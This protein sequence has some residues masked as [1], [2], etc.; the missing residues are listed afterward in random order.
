M[1]ANGLGII[2]F[3]Y[4][5]WLYKRGYGRDT[6]HQYT[7][8]V[9]HFGFWRGKEKGALSGSA[10]HV[11]IKEFLSAQLDRCHCPKPAVTTLKTCRPALHRLLEMLGCTRAQPK[12]ANGLAA[13]QIANFD[14][15]LKEVS[16]LSEATRLYRRRY[17]LEFLEW[18]FKGRG[19]DTTKLRGGDF[20]EYIRLRSSGLKP[21]SVRVMITSLRSWI[22]FV[23]FEG[24]CLSGLSRFLPTVANWKHSLPSPV[25]TPVECRRLL[26]AINPETPVGSRDMAIVRLMLDL[27]LRCSEV[28][29]LSLEDIDWR[30]GTLIIRRNKQRRERLLP[31]PPSVG[32]AIS[33]Y[34]RQGR[35]VSLSRRLFLCHRIPLGDPI[36]VGRVRGAVRRA[37]GR[38]GMTEDGTHRL[39]HAFAT[40]LHERGASLKEVADI[41][42]HQNLDTT[43]IY[44][45]V[46]EVQL[47][48][49]A[50]PWPGGE[51]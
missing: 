22:R 35:P 9:E 21:A 37:M 48:E 10:A 26:G 44:A 29:G 17:V 16:G 40:R 25:L 45:R 3:E 6:I 33:N 31:L 32:K 12:E 7:Q 24:H 30:A 20:L 46:N 27:G 42:G 11:E 47:R 1:A 51:R 36:T 2:L 28:A 50:L 43:A 39:R 49:V 38:S 18:R 8:A 34:L 4:V 23:E 13:A 14:R 19:L 41:L 15:Y 5:D